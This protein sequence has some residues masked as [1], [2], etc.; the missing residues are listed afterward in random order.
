MN[1][2]IRSIF[3]ILLVIVCLIFLR[4]VLFKEEIDQQKSIFEID[5]DNQLILTP[6]YDLFSEELTMEKIILASEFDPNHLL[7]NNTFTTESTIYFI[8]SNVTGVSVQ[9]DGYSWYDVDLY[10]MYQDGTIIVEQSKNLGETGKMV[11]KSDLISPYGLITVPST[12]EAGEY[13]IHVT[14][15]DIYTN[16]SVEREAV[17]TIVS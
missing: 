8:M 4:E 14:F 6:Y 7:E 10:I 12:A 13:T 17:F 3:L 1:K 15:Y 2:L 9:G 11:L 16:E 5:K